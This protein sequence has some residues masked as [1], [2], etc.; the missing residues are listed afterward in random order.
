MK[1][2]YCEKI[3]TRKDNLN[4]H[5]KNFCKEKNKKDNE[6]IILK[7]LIQE[8]NIKH[9]Q[10]L[11][12]MNEKQDLL[13]DKLESM[14]NKNCELENEIRILKGIKGE[15]VN[16]NNNNNIQNNNNNTQINNFN[17]VA[18]GKEKLDE[19]IGEEECKKILFRGFEAV[20][21]LVENVHFNKNR[22]QYHNCLQDF[23]SSCFT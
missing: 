22:T 12:N 23:V 4:R 17:I 9:E 15:I 20:P 14:E 8:M 1:C 5:T 2:D 19:I 13:L 21:Q 16:S 10:L 7:Q 11:I 6:Q 18:F 3:F